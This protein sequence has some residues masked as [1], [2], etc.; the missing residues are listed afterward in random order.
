MK[1]ISKLIKIANLA[2]EVHDLTIENYNAKKLFGQ[3]M[4]DHLCK[5]K[6]DWTPPC[7]YLEFTPNKERRLCDNCKL[8]NRYHDDYI[9]KAHSL[10]NHKAQL[11]KAI[12][13][14]TK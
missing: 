14:Y 8:T 11:N 3:M 6:N 2:I 4:H 7:Y 1:S 9:Y 10:G 13:D 5:F 12:E